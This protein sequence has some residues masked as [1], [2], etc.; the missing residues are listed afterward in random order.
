[1]AHEAS[2]KTGL[3]VLTGA[4]DYASFTWTEDMRKRSIEDIKNEIIKDFENGFEDTKIKPG[5]IGEIGIWDF[6]DKLEMK[7]LSAAAKAQ[8]EIGCALYIH[9]PIWEKKGNDILDILEREKA[10]LNKVVLCHC[11]PTFEDYD[12]HDSLAKRG[13]Y[14]EFDLWGAEFMS[15]EGWFLPSGWEQD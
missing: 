14:I 4:G 15:F 9:P 12:Y 10:D 5:L 11:D 6:S 7:S 13:A 1:M 2:K 8:R 3:N